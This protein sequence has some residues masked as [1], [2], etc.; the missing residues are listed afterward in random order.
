MINLLRKPARS[1]LRL[2]RDARAF[3]SERASF[4][5]LMHKF[6]TLLFLLTLAP[7][8][9]LN[10]GGYDQTA[11]SAAPIFGAFKGIQIDPDYILGA[12]ADDTG[13]IWIMLN[14]EVKERELNLRISMKKGGPYRNWFT[15]SQVLVSAANQGK[16][17]NAWTDWVETT[18]NYVEYWMDEKLILHLERIQP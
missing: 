17:A 6:I 8:L 12:K 14:P 16:E 13:K 15:G 7:V 2:A 9:G 5:S 11:G 18:A 4:L 10:A 3:G 1:I